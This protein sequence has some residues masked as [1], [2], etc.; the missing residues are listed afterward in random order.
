MEP[1]TTRVITYAELA[2][3]NTREDAW[4]A[5]RGKVFNV[6]GYVSSHPGGVSPISK[7]FGKDATSLFNSAHSYVE[8]EKILRGKQMGILESTPSTAQVAKSGLRGGST[9]I[10]PN[11]AT[12]VKNSGCCCLCLKAT[13]PQN[14]NKISFNEDDIN[15]FVEATGMKADADENDWSAIV[16]EKNALLIKNVRKPPAV[17]VASYVLNQTLED[18][19][20]SVLYEDKFQ[21]M[22][23]L[24]LKPEPGIRW[25]L[26]GEPTGD[27]NKIMDSRTSPDD[28]QEGVIIAKHNLTHNVIRFSIE[29]KPNVKL[30]VP[31]G[32][33]IKLKIGNVQRR[34][35]PVCYSLTDQEPPQP[36]NN[37]QVLH[38]IMKIYEDGEFTQL[39]NKVTVGAAGKLLIGDV[40]GSFDKQFFANTG[41]IVYFAGG[42]GITPFIRILEAMIKNKSLV[43]GKNIV[44]IYFNC[45]DRDVIFKE[46]FEQVA[47]KYAWFTFFPIITGSIVPMSWKGIS[48]KPTIELIRNEIKYPASI[49]STK[50]KKILICGSPGFNKCCEE[51]VDSLPFPTK[52]TCI[53]EG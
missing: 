36:Q 29:L 19:R 39:M 48:G 51:L 20:I 1:S 15:V 24:L 13:P 38:F 30:G 12:S 14:P 43:K 32:F 3:H 11:S 33:H 45:T 9:T 34:Y 44:L 40:G 26:L 50:A 25:K 41:L 8:F 6:T 31:L 2:K 5:V 28:M 52:E 17:W 4:L 35:T 37:G 42:S 18:D 7:G 46:E 47:A 22:T 21:K 16:V 49:A 10:S 53:F 23:V 27:N